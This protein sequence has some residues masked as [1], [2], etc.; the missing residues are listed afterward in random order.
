MSRYHNAG[1]VLA[2][3]VAVAL[4]TSLLSAPQTAQA[5]RKSDEARALERIAR[6]LEGRCK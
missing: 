6:A 1:N 5:G 4:A 2:L 3:V